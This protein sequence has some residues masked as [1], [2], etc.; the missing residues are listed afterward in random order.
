MNRVVE[1]IYRLRDKTTEVLKR[2]TRG[3]RDNAN[4]AER[5]S[6]RIEA[7]NRRQQSSAQGVLAAVGR[8]RFAYFAVAGAVV[9]AVQGIG[10]LA[11]AASDQENAE[12]RL[13]TAIKNGAGATDEQIESLAQLASERQRVTRFGDEQTL[14]AQAQLATF[15]LNA[16]QIATLT[17][18][19]QDLA[20]SQRRL[21]RENVDLESSAQL[22]GKALSGNVGQLSR[23]GVILTQ[24]QQETIRLGSANERVAALAEALDENFRGLAESLTPY[25]QGVQN[26]KAAS[27]DF[28]E[29][30]GSVITQNPAVSRALESLTDWFN[31]MGKAVA[32]NAGSIKRFVSGTVEGFQVLKN[33]AD[34]VFDAI[35]LGA[36]RLQQGILK[37]A[38]NIAENL[39]KVT[40][41]SAR[42]SLDRFVADADAKLAELEESSENRF[43]SLGENVAEYLEAGRN[44]TAALFGQTQ[45][46]EDANAA[47]KEGADA[48]R[49]QAGAQDEQAE[50]LERTRKILEKFGVSMQDTE[51]QSS[52]SVAAITAD[53]LQLAEDGQA[54]LDQIAEAANNA[55]EG[56]DAEQIAAYNERLMELVSTG[57]LSVE[58]F[59]A[60]AGATEDLRGKGGET[61][62]E[63]ERL[64]KAIIEANGHELTNIASEVRKLGQAGKLSAQ[65]VEKLRAA[66][67]AKRQAQVQGNETQKQTNKTTEQGAK[68]LNKYAK[69]E[70]EA[71][72]RA[73]RL[74]GAIFLAA[75]AQQLFNQ[76]LA[77]WQGGGTASYIQFWK[78]S[79]EE[80]IEVNREMQ[81]AEERLQRLREQG[82]D[83]NEATEASNRELRFELMRLRGEKERIAELEERDQRRALQAQID[84][85][86]A[87]GDY[88]QVELLKERQRLLEQIAQEEERRA[89]EQE[90]Q[91]EREQQQS[92]SSGNSSGGAQGGGVSTPA[93]ALSGGVQRIEVDLR[94]SGGDANAPRLNPQDM[95]ELERRLTA[96][97]IRQLEVDAQRTFR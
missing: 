62:T 45:A 9:G 4:T 43:Q 73:V 90:R 6:K 53:L 66:I 15:K 71:E 28:A 38:R 50:A 25:E 60:L 77:E 57:R 1:T 31:R 39:A 94:S 52:E 68:A 64:N 14:S 69:G 2:I 32:E 49:D 44:L 75:E 35:L 81:A 95:V 23:Y 21:G 13:A 74:G 5:T 87:Q 18:R 96:G 82:V 54:S 27:G 26:A 42:E 36:N 80:A 65:E 58:Q 88:E 16:E 29:V 97:I 19:V 63:F 17:P 33:T 3:Y 84:L 56:F 67:E 86:A 85:A 55:T 79:L 51:A 61:A 72:G 30:L 59:E 12:R 8:L 41:G 93:P 7:A 46:Q 48:A 24:A 92:Q 40:F 10:R 78:R 34:I 20:E 11:K 91:R 22:V 47:T 83:V 89:R 37:T 70:E 76:R